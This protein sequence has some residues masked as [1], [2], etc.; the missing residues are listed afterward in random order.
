[1]KKILLS[2]T[3]CFCYLFQMSSFSQEPFT[4]HVVPSAIT[5]TP[6]VHSG[7]FASWNGKWIF[8]GGRRDG[9]HIMQANQAFGK[10]ERNDSVYV[11]DPLANSYSAA[12][13]QQLL[14][15]MFDALCSTN[16]Q[17]FQD[18]NFLYMIGGY[19]FEGGSQSWITFP[20]LI[21]INLDSLLG[22]F[23]GGWPINGSFRQVIDS[24][25][26]VTG[27]AL[28]KIDSTYYLVFG[29][30]F[31]GRY[32][33]IASPSFTQRYTHEI[34]K[35]NIDD[36]GINLSVNNYSFLTDT[37]VFHRRDFNMVPQ[38]YP[39]HERGFTVFGGVFRKNSDIPFLTPIDITSGA[40]QHIAGFNEN[41]NQY[42]TASIPI[43]DSSANYMH[44]VFFGGLSLYT[45][46]T[47]NMSLI[48]DTLV[49]FVSTISK[50]TRDSSGVLNESKMQ[51]NMPYLKGANAMFIPAAAT[52]MIDGRILDLN[53]INGNRLV[54]YIAG[55]IH[56][57]A[58]NVANLDPVGM[59]R[60]NAQLYEVY[61]DKTVNEIPEITV[62]N[63]VI[64]LFIYPN[65]ATE[66]LN[67]NF[68]L[69]K[70]GSCEIKLYDVR[71]NLIRTLFSDKKISGSQHFVFSI[72]GIK[73]GTYFCHVKSGKSAKIV[74]VIID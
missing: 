70:E 32:S 27:G 11:V 53:A 67:V 41:L 63:S 34:R 12:S 14:P 47:V 44:T 35:F 4:V 5:A 10:Q 23:G 43:Y 22:A 20:S 33:G 59:S 21:S 38:I 66:N 71:G 72:T 64:D 2:F 18:G 6:A 40:V 58:P 60:P 3:F 54:G 48:Q 73:A 30:N 7:A 65:P 68:T 19:G 39:N 36:D 55:G 52:P 37:D 28:D 24:N 15:Y 25:M 45:L 46:D 56:S 42:T 69:K 13:A 50:M 51:E 16:M 9:M 49:P 1:M 31:E 8:V 61:V 74:R 17:F 26:A 29:H 57:D 62:I